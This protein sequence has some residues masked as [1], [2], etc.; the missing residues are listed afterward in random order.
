MAIQDVS[1]E[2]SGD[3]VDQIIEGLKSHDYYV[4]GPA[5]D[6]LS[7]IPITMFDDNKLF[8]L[9]RNILQAAEG[10]EFKS[11]EIIKSLSSWLTKYTVK[12]ENHV[13]NGILFEIYFNSKGSFR[14]YRFKS[15]YLDD[16]FKLET[17]QLYSQ[18]FKFIRDA[19]NSLRDQLVHIPSDPPISVSLILMFEETDNRLTGIMSVAYKLVSVKHESNEL[20]PVSALTDDDLVFITYG[21]VKTK[22]KKEFC[23]PTNRLILCPNI[24]VE[25]K[26]KILA[27]WSFTS[28]L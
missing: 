16:I 18:S 15:Q 20:L 6:K 21:E 19:L 3:A 28:K 9:G 14:Q 25:D 13:L 17:N 10:G 27:P 7:R 8:I 12:E 26:T 24:E 11:I 2:S 23:I 22:L 1:F 4:Q 5:V